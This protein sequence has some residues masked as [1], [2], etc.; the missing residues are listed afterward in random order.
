MRTAS[1]DELVEIYSAADVF[2]NASY[3]ETMGW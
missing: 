3:E 1:V 2:I